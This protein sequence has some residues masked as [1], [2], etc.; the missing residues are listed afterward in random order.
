MRKVIYKNKI[1]NNKILTDGFGFKFV[2][3]HRYY[4][5]LRK[6]LY[7]N[8]KKKLQKKYLNFLDAQGLAI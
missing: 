5:V 8:D 3:G 2:S 6:W 4:R 7:P 1:I